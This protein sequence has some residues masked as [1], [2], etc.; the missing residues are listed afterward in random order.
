MLEVG[1]WVESQLPTPLVLKRWALVFIC[2][3]CNVPLISVFM[4][5]FQLE[6]DGNLN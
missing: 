4:I 1:T 5:E 2:G 3:F 6:V